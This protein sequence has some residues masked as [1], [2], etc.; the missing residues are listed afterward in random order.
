MA[1]K[2]EKK[3]VEGFVIVVPKAKRNQYKKMAMEGAEAW[4]K[5]GALDYK[6]CRLNDPQPTEYI[7]FTF[8]KMAKAKEDEEVWFSFITYKSK[9]HRNEVNK[10]VMKY[11]G[12]MYGDD[13]SMEMPWDMKRFAQGG[14]VVEVE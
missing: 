2:K 10:E 5:F 13:A 9:K 6:E 12:E 3:Y 4:K 14:F 1:T 8:P 11:F 7:T